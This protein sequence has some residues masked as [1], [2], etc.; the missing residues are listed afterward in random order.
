M[1][2][3][4]PG[5]L[6]TSY[7]VT[8]MGAVWVPLNS[9]LV[10]ESLRFTIDVSDSKFVVTSSRYRDEIQQVVEKVNRSIRI[11]SMDELDEE[12]RRKPAE[13][14]SLAKP[15]DICYLLYTSGTTGLPKGVLHTHNSVIRL[16]VRVEEALATTSD[17]RVYMQL[18]FFHVWAS[19]VMLGV[20]YFKA[21]IVIEEKFDAE[22]YWMNVNEYRITQDHW[23]GTMP[24]NLLKLPQSPLDDKAKMTVFGTFGAMYDVLK[25]RWPNI[26]FQSVYGQ[27]EHGAFTIVPV[28]QIYSGSDGIPKSPDELL[29]VDENGKPVPVG[30]TGEIVM[31]CRCGVR[32]QGYYKNPE[33]TA[34]P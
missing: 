12:A 32:M 21:T 19:L 4:S 28:D 20:M 23:T 30:Q 15:N 31:R 5:L 34:K 17:D 8:N 1:S 3:N 14:K 26:R 25:L 18:P 9:L 27:S 13:Y 24:L 7:A 6:H 10:G 16:G 11:L 22:K 2:E 33:A 29:I